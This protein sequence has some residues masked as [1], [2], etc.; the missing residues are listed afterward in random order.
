MALQLPDDFREFLKLLNSNG[1]EY[2]VVG[3]YAVVYYGAY[4]TTIDM[5]VWVAISPA[6]AQRLAAA[7]EEFGFGTDT[8]SP[9]LFLAKDQI[10][11]FGVPPL[12]LEILTTIS[13]VEFADCYGRRTQA[14]VDDVDVCFIHLDDLQKNK[15]ASGRSKDRSDLRRLKNLRRD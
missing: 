9:D 15:A 8:V 13:G 5:D 6:N 2:L 1:V 11:R 12:R 3:G 10:I 4:R 14:V 7:V